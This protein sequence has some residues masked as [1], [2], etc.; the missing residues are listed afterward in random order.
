MRLSSHGSTSTSVTCRA[1]SVCAADPAAPV[2]RRA[3]PPAPDRCLSAS[4][5]GVRPR[6]SLAGEPADHGTPRT[7]PRSPPHRAHKGQGQWA[8]GHL[9]PLTP[10]ERFKKDDDGLNVRARVE[11]VYSHARLR[12]DRPRRPARPAALVGPLHPAPARHRR[13]QDGRARAARARR[14]VLHAAGPHRRRPADAPSSCGSSPRSRPSSAATPPT[15]PTG[16]TS[17]CTGSASRTCPEIWRRLEAVGLSTTEACGDT[18]RVILGSPVA[19]IAAD[20]IS[21]ARP[22]IDAI[23]RALHRLAGVLQPAAQV[24]DRD[25]RLAAAGRRA[26]GQRHL[27]RRRRAPRARPGLRP[28]GRRRAVDQPDARPAARRLGAAAT[29]VAR[30]LGRRRRRVP[31]LRLPPAAHPGPDQ[32]PG[33]RLGRGEVPRRCSRTS[34]SAAPL[35]DGPAPPVPYGARDHIGVHRQKDGRY[36]VG[37]APDRRPGLRHRC[38]PG[39]PTSPRQ[40]GSQRVRTTPHQKLV[41]LDVPADRVDSLV[42]AAA[43]LGL[44]ARPGT[45]R[46]NTMACTGIE[47]CKLAIV[48]TKARGGQ[49]DRRARAPAARLRRAADDQRQR[50]PQLL[51]PGPGRRHRPQGPAGARTPT[52][53]RSRAS[54]CTSAAGSAW[55]PAS[56]ASCAATR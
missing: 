2:R 5:P 3:V 36:Y 38:S 9:E 21:T 46:R 25:Q 30:R 51:R 6:A 14:R 31:R 40:H 42:D 44:R 39:W 33:R 49:A 56:A 22:A 23:Q 43:G 19:G 52:A 12:L 7:A 16:R 28:L 53:T 15:S 4:L 18:P 48:E 29:D 45:F 50:L 8:L 54:R 11:N 27:V 20:E 32:V 41:V 35:T 1:R 26:R 17:S 10:N 55:T 34:T 13:R 37:L 24:Q 47:F